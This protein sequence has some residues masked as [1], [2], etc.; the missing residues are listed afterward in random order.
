MNIYSDYI[1]KIKN[2]MTEGVSLED[3]ILENRNQE[4]SKAMK[5][6]SLPAL[7]KSKKPLPSLDNLA[8]VV[9]VTPNYDQELGLHPDF[10]HL[11][12]TENIEKHYIISLFIDIKGSTNLFRKYSPETVFVI[13]N[14]IQRAAIHTCLIFGG[15]VQRLQG[16]GLFV[17]YG[18]KSDVAADAT[19]RALTAT[20]AFTYF[21]QNDLKNL[22][23]EQGVEKIYTHI[24]IDYGESQDVVWA[25]AG[26]GQISE[27]TTCSLHTSLA[28]KMLN[29]AQSNGIVVGDNIIN[30]VDAEYFTVVSKRTNQEKDRYIFQ[31][32]QRNFYYT[33]YDFNWMK[34][35]RSLD[36]IATDID[37]GI[38]LKMMDVPRHIPD[39][40]PIAGQSKPYFSK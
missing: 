38:H 12:E 3:L 23:L 26:L 4:L 8:R 22:F 36:Y 5:I 29:S 17:Y 28:S 24:G 25:K 19:K 39:L 1:S 6:G 16:D 33:Q 7:E 35:L 9:G 11:K 20:A 31:D 18:G 34:Y 13:T 40:V 15:Y 37:G 32:N 10:E 30:M 27:V 21:V 14:T 2:A